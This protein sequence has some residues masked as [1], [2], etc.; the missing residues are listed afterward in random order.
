[1]LEVEGLTVELPGLGYRVNIL[2]QGKYRMFAQRRSHN[3]CC[4][5]W[6]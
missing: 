6:V 5:R 3:S 4:L 1:M 2:N